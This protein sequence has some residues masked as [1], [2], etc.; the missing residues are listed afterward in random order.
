MKYSQ[1]LTSCLVTFSICFTINASSKLNLSIIFR[2]VMI[3]LYIFSLKSGEFLCFYSISIL[4][5]L[6]IIISTIFIIIYIISI[7]EENEFKYWLSS[8]KCIRLTYYF[9]LI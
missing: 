7:T 2:I 6:S 1:D 9:F 3:L 4:F 8:N 5:A